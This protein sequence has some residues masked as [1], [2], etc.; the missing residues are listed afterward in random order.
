MT[1]YNKQK[2]RC[3]CCGKKSERHELM[4]SNS[5]GSPDLDQ[6]PPG[7]FGSTIDDWLQECPHCGYVAPVIDKG[8]ERARSFVTTSEFRT[9]SRDPSADSEIRRF[10]VRAAH[11]VYCGD[12]ESAFLNTLCAAWIADDRKRLS[13]AAAFRLKA[14]SYLDRDRVKSID[15]RLIL[16]DVLRRASRWEAAEALADQMAAEELESP[17]AEI[18]AFHRS[19]VEAKDNGRYTIAEALGREDHF[20]E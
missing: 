9:I 11:D 15:T 18:V 1:T 17:F 3:Y 7:M 10:L 20:E 19:K 13:D 2:R 6:R 12:P 16:L 4:S 5:F 8:D 14:A